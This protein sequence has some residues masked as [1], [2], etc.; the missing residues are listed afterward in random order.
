ML[1]TEMRIQVGAEA[2]QARVQVGMEHVVCDDGRLGGHVGAGGQLGHLECW[3]G[4]GGWER[5]ARGCLRTV[6]VVTAMVSLPRD[7]S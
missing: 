5:G 3:P 1:F 6:F 7:G 4:G 2:G